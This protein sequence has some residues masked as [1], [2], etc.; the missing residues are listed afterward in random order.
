MRRVTATTAT[1]GPGALQP[2]GHQ[3]ASTAGYLSARTLVACGAGLA[4]AS[5][6]AVLDDGRAL[7]PLAT[8]A[9]SCLGAGGLLWRRC[10]V[11]AS[12][13]TASV[14]AAVLTGWMLLIG[15]GAA[16]YLACGTFD[17]LELA[18]V[19]STTGFTTTALSVLGDIEDQPR[20]VL[21]WRAY[22]Q[23]LGGLAAVLVV[24]A[25]LP[26][27]GVGGLEESRVGSDRRRLALRSPRIVAVAR[28]LASGYLVL[29]AAG[30]LLFLLA[31]MGPFDA[32]TY[33]MTT[34]STGGFGNHDGS[35]NFFESARVEWV[36]AGGMVL[37]GTNLVLVL[38][39]VR[40]RVEPLRRSFELRV[41][42]IVIV[43]ASALLVWWTAPSGGLTHESI[44]HAV[45]AAT[46]AVSTT[47]HTVG[48][49]AGW[50]SG[51]QVL[52]VFLAGMGA[53]SGA[54]GG[55]FRV[56]RS[57]V[58]MGFVRREV[59]RQLRPRSVVA[60]KVGRTTVEE[61]LLGQMVGYQVA[62]LL[63]AGAGAVALAVAGVDLH[64][65]MTG[66]VSALATFGP[67]LGDFAPGAGQVP[68][69]G[70]L[71]GTA[72]LVFAALTVAGRLEISP[73]VVGAAT[74]FTGAGRESRLARVKRR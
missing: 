20:G 32:V 51:S 41:Y 18:V 40:G 8:A 55:G 48:G 13:R 15:V 26:S 74:I 34:I 67:G 36:T 45:F 10:G 35:I 3:V 2:T 62:W 31:G 37:G 60:V 7:V 21:L 14:H 70:G 24:V 47:G 46:S 5:V 58:L 28:R 30:I 50:S 49:W 69:A 72:L 52:L 44:R 66:A 39:A 12:L 59:V 27:L 68:R 53:M 16:T 42:G 56:V 54:A 9:A 23:W 64:G 38:A 43:L 4:V 65:A 73:V 71:P 11:P 61:S 63:L 29:S 6:L 22:T 1:D 33:A 17:S 57:M 19:E 25:V